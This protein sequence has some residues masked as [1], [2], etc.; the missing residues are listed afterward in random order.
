[1]QTPLCS[2]CLENDD[3]LCNGCRSKLDDGDITQVD[4]DLSRLLYRLSDKI[5]TLEDITI[6]R[7]V[8]TS[9]AVVIL[10]GKGDGPKVVGRD[11]RVVK[12][13]ADEFDKSIRVV[14]DT[15]EVTEV[16]DKLL[17][18][19]EYEGIRTV[20]R[21]DGE[22]KKVT[23]DEDYEPRVPFTKEEFRDLVED[24]TGEMIVL[25]YE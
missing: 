23:V 25:S 2:V 10:T 7:T 13:I 20:Y 16:V 22:E 17:S 4:V 14:E 12:K 9:N 8:Q 3:I 11:G 15:G 6:K 21:P 24:L 18:P 1:M 5:G 19:V